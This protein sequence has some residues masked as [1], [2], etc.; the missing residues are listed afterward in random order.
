MK[1]LSSTGQEGVRRRDGKRGRGG[2]GGWQGGEGGRRRQEK[3]ED[4]TMD[5]S[6]DLSRQAA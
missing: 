1:R 6:Q 2:K 3:A 5:P 4:E